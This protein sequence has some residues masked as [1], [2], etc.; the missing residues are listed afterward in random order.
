MISL[1]LTITAADKPGL[2]ELLS[3]AIASHQGNWQESSMS[4]LAGKFAGILTVTVPETRAEPLI[5]AL[6]SLEAKGL[7]VIVEHT[8]EPAQEENYNRITVELVGHDK[9]GIVKEISQALTNHKITIEQLNT[10]LVSAA[11][12]AEELFKADASL[13]VPES[14][15][16]DDLQQNLEAIASDLMVDITI[17]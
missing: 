11:M 5:P 9:P 3:Q 12:T 7:Q 13:L 1:V 10:E 14:V 15:D 4:R 2:V 6:S 17:D 16:L 8:L